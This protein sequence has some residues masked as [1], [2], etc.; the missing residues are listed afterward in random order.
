M[1]KLTNE[2]LAESFVF[3][4]NLSKEE[5]EKA[6]KLFCEFRKERLKQM[7]L[8]QKIRCKFLQIKFKVQDY[9]KNGK[10]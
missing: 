9:F 5:K 6:E 4:S 3:P 1:K 10:I 2:E 7:T 8:R